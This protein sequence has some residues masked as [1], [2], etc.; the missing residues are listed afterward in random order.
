MASSIAVVQAVAGS[1]SVPVQIAVKATHAD[2]SVKHAVLVAQQPAINSDSSLPLM[3]TTNS[4]SNI[5][6]IVDLGKFPSP[7]VTVSLSITQPASQT[8]NVDVSQA[9]KD[10]LASNSVSYFFQGPLASQ[11]RIILPVVSSF[12]IA[13][14]IT[15]F[16]DDSY[17]VDIQY[18]NDIA[19]A[20]VAYS[21]SIT[22]NGKTVYSAS[23]LTHYQYQTW[24][25][26]YYSNQEPLVNVQFDVLNMIQSNAIAPYYD[27]RG[28]NE[29]V[30]SNALDGINSATWGKPFDNYGVTTAMP[31]TGGRADLG[32]LPLYTAAWIIS[33]HNDLRRYMLG[34]GEAAGSTPLNYF[35]K[36]E[37][38]WLNVFDYPRL[39]LD[40]RCASYSICPTQFTEENSWELD[41]AHLPNMAF[42]PYMITGRRYFLDRMEA[43]AAWVASTTWDALRRQGTEVEMGL[44]YGE[45]LRGAAWGLREVVYAS[46]ISPDDT[47]MRT[48]YDK[49]IFNHLSWLNNQ[50]DAW[51]VKTG[52]VYGIMLAFSYGG[53]FIVPPWQTDFFASTISLAS[54]QGYAL[55]KEFLKWSKNWDVGR[56]LHDPPF[57][58]QNGV[59]Y[60]LW[61]GDSAGFVT[62]WAQ[63]QS[64][65]ESRGL[66]NV[67]FKE[68]NGYYSQLG[69][70]TLVMHQI[71]DPTDPDATSAFNW[72]STVGAPYTSDND[73][74]NDPT[75]GMATYPTRVNAPD[76]VVIPALALS[77]FSATSFAVTLSGCS[78]LFLLA[79]LIV[80]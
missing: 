77:P 18:L 62:T 70:M 47:P 69:L 44:L 36:N 67:D 40:A 22:S 16:S 50:T 60:N 3:L 45:Q 54:R 79:Q 12:R 13:L 8:F 20:P 55:A 27:T 76:T 42:V 68:S 75:F 48:Y 73:F 80:L 23:D 9:L 39:W 41:T 25:Y 59:A 15:L 51:T 5:E 30:V 2:G 4:A 72:L 14:D 34:W 37:S 43:V 24:H 19:M 35:A 6:S 61:Y 57:N 21:T 49:I 52:E 26:V 10:A 1:T 33:Q 64:E 17:S 38:R 56:F 66:N 65:Q 58:K 71:E 74:R 63:F 11:G 32:P 53:D 31:G 7:S 46:Y 29:G 78:V 28:I